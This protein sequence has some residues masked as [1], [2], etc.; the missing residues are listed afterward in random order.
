V[1]QTSHHLHY[2]LEVKSCWDFRSYSGNVGYEKGRCNADELLCVP[3]A[4]GPLCG[5]CKDGFIYS[6][7]DRTC[8]A[9]K[10]S[11]ARV[12][13]ALGT[14]AC[15]ALLVAL[16]FVRARPSRALAEFMK[17]FWLWGILRQVDG[18]ALRVAWSNYQ[19]CAHAR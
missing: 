19:V 7:A 16:T 8:I 15:V 9:C 14:L 18:G 6:S 1:A 2:L 3:G 11:M 10:A 4:N 5:S 12:I 17:T 13:V